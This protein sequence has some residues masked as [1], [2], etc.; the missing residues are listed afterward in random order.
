MALT[1]CVNGVGNGIIGG[2]EPHRPK[3]STPL[4]SNLLLEGQQ[5]KN[6]VKRRCCYLLPA[7]GTLARVPLM[8]RP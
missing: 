4:S 8:R 1:E 7:E 6:G 3:Y 2:E 5:K